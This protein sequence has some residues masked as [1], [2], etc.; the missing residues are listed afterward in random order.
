MLMQGK[1]FPVKNIGTSRFA[2]TEVHP[3]P[4]IPHKRG[5]RGGVFLF[6]SQVSSYKSHVPG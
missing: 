2:K 6:K 1:P 4:V 3:V 5:N